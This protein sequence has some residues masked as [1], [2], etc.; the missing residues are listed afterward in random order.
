M[1]LLKFRALLYVVGKYN[2]KKYISL[3]FFFFL[4]QK[5]TLTYFVDHETATITFLTQ[6]YHSPLL[7]HTIN[8]YSLR[9]ER[10]Y[11]FFFFPKP[12]IVMLLFLIYP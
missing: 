11:I 3:M 1:Q 6:L 8:Y 9:V 7:W 2:M 10:G 4:T 5:L 12:M